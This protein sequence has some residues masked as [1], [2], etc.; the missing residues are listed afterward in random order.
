[1]LVASPPSFGNF[2]GRTDFG[3]DP[4]AKLTARWQGNID[5][6]TL[7]A[8]IESTEHSNFGV[9]VETSVKLL[10]VA[11]MLI[12]NGPYFLYSDG[13]CLFN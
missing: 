2:I 6:K 9:A 10:G 8:A 13:A 12:F 3:D 1:M 5:G 7:L 4:T 11:G